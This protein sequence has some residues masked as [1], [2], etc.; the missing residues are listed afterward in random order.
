ML[1]TEIMYVAVN[2]VYGVTLSVTVNAVPHAALYTPTTLHR[3]YPLITT[4][5][6]KE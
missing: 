3:H 6:T 5:V 4:H 2:T 1:C